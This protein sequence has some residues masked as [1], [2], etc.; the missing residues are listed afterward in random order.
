[1]LRFFLQIFEQYGMGVLQIAIILGLAWKFGTNHL[2]HLQDAI[3]N[4]AKKLD[5][6]ETKLNSVCERIAKIEGKIGQ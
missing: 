4:V 6:Q 2:K 5:T 1:M 3:D